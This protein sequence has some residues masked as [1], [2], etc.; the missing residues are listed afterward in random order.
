MRLTVVSSI[1]FSALLSTV[2]VAQPV[3]SREPSSTHVFPAGGRRGTTVPVL[4]G[5]ECIPPESRF[6]I[7]GDGIL[8]PRI[9][10]ATFEARIEPSP[11]REPREVPICYPKEWESKIEIA[12]DTELGP[13]MW[14]L[15]CA[16]GGTGTRPF[17]V[18]DLPEFIETESNSLPGRAE[19]VE[20][21]VTV[22]GRIAGESDLDYF[23]FHADAG[24]VVICDVVAAR[25]GSPLDPVVEMTDAAGRRVVA[26]ELHVGSDPVLAFRAASSGDYRLF[27]SNVSLH[28]G[29]AHVYR[30][31]LTEVAAPAAAASSLTAELLERGLVPSLAAVAR[32]TGVARPESAKGVVESS[33]RPAPPP[34][35]ALPATIRGRFDTAADEDEFR[36]RA[37]AGQSNTIACRAYPGG[38]PTLPVV[39]VLDADGRV[40]AECKSVDSPDRE[41]W[42]D[43]QAPADGD[44]RLR[45]R[46]VQHGVR[47]GPEFGYELIVRSATPDFAMR[48]KSDVVNVVQGAKTELEVK[49]RRSGGLRG[50]IDLAAEGLPAGVRVEPVRIAAD[51]DTARFVVVADADARPADAVLRVIGRATMGDTLIERLAAAPHLGRDPEGVS[52]GSPETDRLQLTVQHKPVFRL[53]CN[54]AYQYAH[55]GTIYPYAMQVERLDGFDGPITIQLSDRQNRDL[56]GVEF[57]EMTVP[58]G[59]TDALVPIHFPE[60]MHINVLSQSQI[61]AQSYAFFTDKW[62][63]RQSTLVVS[64]KRNM[65]RTMPTVVK[66]VAADK[67]IV[68]RP[69]EIVTCR[70]QLDRT[71]N[72][73]GPMDLELVSSPPDA[74]AVAEKTTIEANQTRVDVPIRLDRLA[75]SRGELVLKFRARGRMPSGA[76]V[77]SEATVSVRIE[78]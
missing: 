10:G 25:L 65:V 9:L 70:L 11:R 7:F 76:T 28:G 4:V 18:G 12:A 51:Q 30:V 43:W 67:Q 71:S 15:S 6:L 49:V 26:E 16:R 27:V 46:D 72:F 77:V 57:I 48:V 39:A 33:Q 45:L 20:L 34:T 22:N 64:E 73:S 31:T 5:G 66:L 3:P 24:A 74:R 13:S 75:K 23:V 56:D 41:C 29:P 8:A 52:V 62:G 60:S 32:Q 63:Q 38:M 53:H 68:A 59:Q 47:G 2:A 55:R 21:P 69:N 14:R 17:I 42:L 54:E 58:P 50:A 35:L 36:F 37:V 44:Y 61:Y 1:L 19:R 40:V 78:P